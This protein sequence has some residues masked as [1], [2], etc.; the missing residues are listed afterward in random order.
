MS[1]MDS[2][3]AFFGITR[4]TT[5]RG[6]DALKRADE[7]TLNAYRLLGRLLLESSARKSLVWLDLLP[8]AKEA[9][10]VLWVGSHK[11]GSVIVSSRKFTHEISSFFSLVE[12]DRVFR[13]AIIALP[14][15]L[16]TLT[17]RLLLPQRH[18]WHVCMMAF[19][20][21]RNEQLDNNVGEV[22][23]WGS[24]VFRSHLTISR[25]NIGTSIAKWGNEFF[26]DFPIK[27]H[28]GRI[29]I[30]QPYKGGREGS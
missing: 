20:L 25:E 26:R 7:T 18:V 24:D 14:E 19:M 28:D 3:L 1:F 8:N 6:S 30:W 4:S 23:M 10:R 12:Q 13:R 21:E 16:A 11:S 5:V 27:H 29:E 9:Q 2:I 22:R 17:E 15:A